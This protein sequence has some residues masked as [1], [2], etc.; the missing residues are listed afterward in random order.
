M[1]PVQHRVILPLNFFQLFLCYTAILFLRIYCVYAVRGLSPYSLIPSVDLV[2]FFDTS[3][4]HFLCTIQSFYVVY[5][6]WSRVLL[7]FLFL[8]PLV[9]H[10]S[11][12]PF[13]HLVPHT[14]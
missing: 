6:L 11:T 5:R 9:I 3:N 10:R 12:C 13:L 4:R 8:F 2:I 14:R 7:F 1:I